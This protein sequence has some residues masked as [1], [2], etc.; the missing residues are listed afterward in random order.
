MAW[1]LAH[2]LFSLWEGQVDTAADLTALA[3]AATEQVALDGGRWDAA[4]L[5]TLL[6]EP[7]PVV[8]ER[9]PHRLGAQQLR[10]F[11]QLWD[12]EWTTVLMAYIRE[13]DLLS[14]R[15]REMSGAPPAAQPQRQPPPSQQPGA[16][17]EPGR[18]RRGRGRGRGWQEATPQA[19]G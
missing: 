11:S 8:M 4:F 1:I 14:T 6:E 2:V 17:A 15:R 12:Q 18:G 19:E 13:L 5:L 7:P 16:K 9:R 10:A 3:F